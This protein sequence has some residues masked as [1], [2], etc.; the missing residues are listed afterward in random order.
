MNSERE[1][2]IKDL[3]EID[4]DNNEDSVADYILADR[5]RLLAPLVEYRGSGMGFSHAL[6]AIDA[7]LRLAGLTEDK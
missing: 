7:T 6:S 4:C 3:Q 1:R 5:Q 2:L